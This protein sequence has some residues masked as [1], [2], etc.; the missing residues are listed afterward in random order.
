MR[1]RDL[2]ALSSKVDGRKRDDEE[3]SEGRCEMAMSYVPIGREFIWDGVVDRFASLFC[4]TTCSNASLICINLTPPL[5]YEQKP[6]SDRSVWGELLAALW[7]G[8]VSGLVHE[9]PGFDE[10]LKN[11]Q[12]YRFW[13][14]DM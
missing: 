7:S 2:H 12:L 11:K 14:A 10:A 8:G 13:L 9:L 4:T 5:C 6:P 3:E 1:F